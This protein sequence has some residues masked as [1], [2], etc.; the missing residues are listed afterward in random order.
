MKVFGF[1]LSLLLGAC[2]GDKPSSPPPDPHSWDAASA[3]A[4]DQGEGD[5]Y[6]WRL[7]KAG[8]RLLAM[9][10]TSVIWRSQAYSAGWQKMTWSN[11]GEPNAWH[12]EGDS[13]WIGTR[14][15]G[16]LYACR[17][18][19]WTCKDLRMP[20]PDSAEVAHVTRFQEKVRA[21]ADAYRVRWVLTLDAAGWGDWDNGFPVDVPYR[22]LVVGDTLWAASWEHGLWYRVGSETTWKKQ[23]SQRETW[24]TFRLDSAKNPRGLAWHHGALWVADWAGEVTRMPGAHAPYQAVGNCPAGAS[25]PNCRHQPTNIFSLLSYKDRLYVGGFFGAAPFVLDE[26]TGFWI[27]TEIAGWCWNDGNT[28]GGKRTWDLV[29]L[30]DTLYSASSRYIM[31]L[32]L[33]KVPVFDTSMMTR[34]YWNPDT[35]RRDSIFRR[36]NPIGG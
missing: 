27:T 8:T 7:T 30:G 15:P 23:Q 9:T 25:L 1:G 5:E 24:K 31:K 10:S 16:R 13:V 20:I 14:K 19:D 35:S 3:E 11:T 36:N 22:T 28:C 2:S 12:A 29:G 32:P 21:F 33:S 4:P 34:F 17:V 26:P 18:S 6:W